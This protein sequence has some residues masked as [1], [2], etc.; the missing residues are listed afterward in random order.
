MS[1]EAMTTV[2][3]MLESLPEPTQ[4]QIVE[5]LRE[6]VL[7]IQDEI[8]WDRLFNKTQPKLISMARLAKK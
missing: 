3:K 1:S 7:E 6:Y 8:R 4:N 5:H 2:V